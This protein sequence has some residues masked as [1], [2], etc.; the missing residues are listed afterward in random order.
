MMNDDLDKLIEK[1]EK[2]FGFKL[3]IKSRQY[4]GFTETT[5]IEK[6]NKAGELVET[7]TCVDG[8]EVKK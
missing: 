8:K 7:R 5:F 1:Y 4:F 2:K 6:F 3:D